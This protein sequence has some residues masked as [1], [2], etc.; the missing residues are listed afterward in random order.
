VAEE[1]VHLIRIFL[2]LELGS[3]DMFTEHTAAEEL[4]LAETRFWEARFNKVK[5]L[6]GQ[7]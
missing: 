1:W 5:G 6:N 4:P 3:I 7:V 2:V